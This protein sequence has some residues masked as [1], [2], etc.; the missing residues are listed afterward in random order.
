LIVSSN[1]GWLAVLE[2]GSR[3]P[4]L[5]GI[6]AV[7]AQ[8]A[9]NEN[10]ENA[11]DSRRKAMKAT[12]VMT[13]DV[14]TVHPDASVKQIAETLA[15]N[16]ISAVPVVDGEG[17]LV[18]M[19]SEGDLLHRRET[20][21]ERR[22]SWWLL[23]FGGNDIL[24]QDYVKSHGQKASDVMTRHVLSVDENTSLGEVASLLDKAGIKRVP[25]LA[26]GR[27]VGI[28]SRADL[29]RALVRAKQDEPFHGTRSDH[30][31]QMDLDARM[32]RE[33]W[34]GSLCIVTTVHDGTVDLLGLAS[35]EDQ[36]KGL[37]V[38]AQNI[39]GVKHVED[40]LRVRSYA[41]D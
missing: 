1:A 25:V 3:I 23:L 7:R 11:L 34:A 5:I 29:V 20:A 2:T 30:E 38:L 39:A 16:A 28:L 31:I 9:P 27:L 17:H 40:R 32:K 6:N 8:S 33:P 12:D 10:N 26:G 19:V 24:A 41:E 13:K 14:V 22:R 37:I 21:T 18:G 36:R 4:T 15:A 35:S